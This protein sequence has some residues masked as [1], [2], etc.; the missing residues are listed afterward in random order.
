MNISI[1]PPVKLLK[2]ALLCS[3]ALS[4]NL[5]ARARDFYVAQS[6]LGIGDGS[7][8]ANAQPVAW[9]NVGVNWG[10]AAGQINAGDTVHL[11]GTIN[12]T[13]YVSGSGTLNSAVTLYFEPNARISLP[14]GNG[15]WFLGA[16]S[17]F[18]ID[19]GTNGIIE[20]TANGTGLANQQS[21]AGVY[22][23]GVNNL[24]VKNLHINN[25]YVHTNVADI[26]IDIA[27]AGGIYLNGGVGNLVFT[28]NTFS[29]VGWCIN[30]VSPALGSMIQIQNCQFY[31]YDHGVALSGWPATIDISS[32]RFDTTANWD[33]TANRYHHDGIHYFGGTTNM[34]SFMI[35]GNLFTGNYGANNTAHIYLETAPPNVVLQNNVFLQYPGN[36]LNNGF[37]VVSGNNNRI[38]NNTFLGSGVLN[39]T[40][41]SIGGTN[42][43][44]E[45]NLFSGTTGFIGVSGGSAPHASYNLYA[46][47]IGAGG[48]PFGFNAINYNTFTSWATAIGETHS[49][50]KISANIN[51]DGTLRALSPA[52]GAG[53]DLSV[54]FTNDFSGSVRTAPWDIGAYA[55][56]SAVKSS[57]PP[58][59][60]K[61]LHLVPK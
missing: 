61:N 48:S 58:P 55:A 24:T 16:I 53:G 11:V 20:N 6:A 45:N 19:G 50:Y 44:I 38:V 22:A 46:N 15:I 1:Y 34:V 42:V 30:L 31:N 32:N 2:I 41:L 59:A 49:N 51:A 35:A 52:I 14:A 47:Q 5:T 4:V 39:S 9:L 36:Y 40:A 56:S 37:A 27:A 8:P 33:N 23:P 13:V 21:W 7:S 29:N 10:S 28:G 12:N 18:V 57:G 25:M 60:P 3:F 54:Y 43:S 17:N 26:S